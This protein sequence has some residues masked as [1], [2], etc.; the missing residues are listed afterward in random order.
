MRRSPLSR[1]QVDLFLVFSFLVLFL[2]CWVM[3]NCHDSRGAGAEPCRAST[4]SI[5]HVENSRLIH[6]H[7]PGTLRFAL[8]LTGIGKLSTCFLFALFGELPGARCKMR[9]FHV[10]TRCCNLI[11]G[12]KGTNAASQSSKIGVLSTTVRFL[13]SKRQPRRRTAG[14][15]PGLPTID[16][17]TRPASGPPPPELVCERWRHP[18]RRDVSP[19]DGAHCPCQRAP[20]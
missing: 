18:V 16:A 3:G 12:L 13:F 1:C 7:H 17:I 19:T 15:P 10:E 8:R 4:G 2:G 20:G 9:F 5:V 11:R 6:H 14:T